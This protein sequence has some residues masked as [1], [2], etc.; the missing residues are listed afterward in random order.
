MPCRDAD[1]AAPELPGAGALLSRRRGIVAN[2]N[3]LRLWGPSPLQLVALSAPSVP[4]LCFLRQASSSRGQIYMGCLNCPGSG[5]I[6]M[7]TLLRHARAAFGRY[8]NFCDAICPAGLSR[9]IHPL[10][11]CKKDTPRSTARMTRTS[12]VY[13]YCAV[14]WVRRRKT[15]KVPATHLQ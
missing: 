9:N 14:C 3:T 7:P 2:A 1:T 11:N 15:I 5:Q 10:P 4:S 6:F 13:P 12:Y 8:V